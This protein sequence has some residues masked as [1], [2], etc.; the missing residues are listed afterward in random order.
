MT[1]EQLAQAITAAL[2]AAVADGQIA[3][4]IPAEVSLG[5]RVRVAHQ[6]GIVVHRDAVIGDDVRLRQNVT[7]GL[8]RDDVEDQARNVP[9][10]GDGVSLGAGA[11]VVGAGG[12]PAYDA[13]VR[14]PAATRSGV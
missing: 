2:E 3:V 14:V 8:H 4:E 7:I 11:V 1:P 6:S 9:T 12:G 13:T 5:R 10:I